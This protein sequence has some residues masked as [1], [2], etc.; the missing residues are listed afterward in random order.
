MPKIIGL[1]CTS[2]Q[3]EPIQPII[4]SICDRLRGSSEYRMVI[5]HCFED[6]YYDDKNNRGAASVFDLINFDMPDV[7]VIAATSILN[8]SVVA[9]IID[10]CAEH[11]VPA[12]TIDEPHEGASCISFDYGEA[13]SKIVEHIL[14]K[15]GARRIKLVAG[16]RGNEFS[17]TRI[18][19][20]AE[21][22]SRFG[23][24]LTP[25]DIMYGDFWEQPTYRAMDEFFASGEPLPDAFICCNDSMAIAVCTKLREHGYNIP[26]DVIVSG[27]DGI[28]MEKYHSPRL[29]TAARDNSLLSKSLFEM[30]ERLTAGSQ[31][32]SI[33]LPYT[34]VFSE[35][36]GCK[37]DTHDV[38]KRLIDFV[39]SHSVGRIFEEQ[40]NNM[41]HVIAAEPTME[42]AREVLR[43]RA[44]DNTVICITEELYKGMRS[45]FG[46]GKI[47]AADGTYPDT[48]RV[49]MS[50][51]YDGRNF[52]DIVFPTAELLPDFENSFGEYNT[53]FIMPLHFRD[54]IAGYFMTHYCPMEHYNEMLYTFS[55][56]LNSCIETMNMHE[57][58]TGLNRKMEYLF[59]HDQLTG[60]CN[61]YGFYNS[62]KQ[63][64][65]DL[66]GKAR[67][68][69]II[70]I[71]LNDM[72]YIND[73]FGHS[74]GDEALS[75]TAQALTEAADGDALVICSRFG[76]DEF[77][78]ARICEGDSKQRAE[79]YH[80]RFSETLTRLNGA[81]G[82]PFSVEASVGVFSADL[83]DV[84]SVDRL[85]ELADRLMY[86]DKARYK[87]HPRS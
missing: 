76:G 1:C 49:F 30:I 54:S 22:M 18:N 73:N 15:H 42:H 29:T 38:C 3:K 41:S 47:S 21:V 27:F 28:E 8:K 70:S 11:G 7:M 13:F 16:L 43:N 39:Q 79:S 23:L 69:F 36:C 31:P 65:T 5:Y 35:S 32:Y 44:F 9:R 87:R 14:E 17:Q 60:I 81:S 34:P 77:V 59:T 33:T 78:V 74:C 37:R 86:N 67:D 20:C 85:I 80:K 4:E 68:V 55:S 83:T 66:A 24:T 25:N 53:F 58:L 50:K 61:R 45:E 6:L 71:D 52:D 46:D 72:K 57:R 63:N 26:Q 51:Y 64:Y 2:A 19:S 12:I 56:Y 48:M 40:M 10:R 62:F 84:D 75:I 82:K